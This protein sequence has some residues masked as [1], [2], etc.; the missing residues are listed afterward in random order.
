MKHDA[1]YPSARTLQALVKH[2]LAEYGMNG[3][4]SRKD[5]EGSDW[6]IQT[7]ERNDDRRLWISVCGGVNTLTQA[8]YK[9]RATTP[10]TEGDRLI[11][12]LS[13]YIYQAQIEPNPTAHP[14]MC[15][16]QIAGPHGR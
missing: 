15:Q 5:S 13:V 9:L 2:S 1:N 11:A 14:A 10:A 8:L 6:I 3:V 16:A 7:L 12:K 4:G